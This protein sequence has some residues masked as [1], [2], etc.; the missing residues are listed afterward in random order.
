LWLKGTVE[1]RKNFRKAYKDA[2]Y[3]DYPSLETLQFVPRWTQF[4]VGDGI[5]LDIMTSMKGLE[6]KSFDE[7]LS[8]SRVADLD[9]VL[10]PFFAYK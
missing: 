1:N 9:G 10:V 8:H 4:Y 6:G 2:G 7:S 5:I 3:G